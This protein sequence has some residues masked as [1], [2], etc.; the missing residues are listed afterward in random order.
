MRW[1]KVRV[2][3]TEPLRGGVFASIAE[4]IR[5]NLHG[6]GGTIPSPHCA[7]ATVMWFMSYKHT[8]R[9][10]ILL[11]PIILSLYVSTVY[12]RFHYVSDMIIGIAVAV[13]A[14]LA[15]PAIE[16]AWNR[17]TDKRTGGAS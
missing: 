15:A 1:E 9:G 2:L 3:L 14:L 7:V 17:W 12:G 8:R 13:L 4:Y 10:F 6:A 11:A 16:R 5:A